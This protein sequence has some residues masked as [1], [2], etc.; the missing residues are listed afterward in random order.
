MIDEELD[1]LILSR[2]RHLR[3]QAGRGATSTATQTAANM[4]VFFNEP[5]DRVQARIRALA[6]EDRIKESTAVLDCWM[7]A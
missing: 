5:E 2:L 4:A 7:I 3:A 1:E 6:G